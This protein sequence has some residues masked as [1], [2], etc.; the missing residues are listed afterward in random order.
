M[1]PVYKKQP[2]QKLITEYK[3]IFSESESNTRSTLLHFMEIDLKGRGYMVVRTDDE[4][5]IQ[6][7]TK[8]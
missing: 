7:R 2:V 1:L 4:V 6:R 3:T 5:S 8:L